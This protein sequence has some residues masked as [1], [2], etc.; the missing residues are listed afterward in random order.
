MYVIPLSIKEINSVYLLICRHVSLAC[1]T[2]PLLYFDVQIAVSNFVV[3]SQTVSNANVTGGI[4]CC[5]RDSLEN[6]TEENKL[7]DKPMNTISVID[8]RRRALSR[9]YKQ[10]DGHSKTAVLYSNFS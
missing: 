9:K 8:D 6:I 5:H 4:S 10:S 2:T 7:T 3:P 1:V